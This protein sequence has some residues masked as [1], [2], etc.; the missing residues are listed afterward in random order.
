MGRAF[1]AIGA[2]VVLGGGAAIGYAVT[3]KATSGMSPVQS[4]AMAGAVAQLDGDIK[5]ARTAVEVRAST[6]STLPQVRAALVTDVGT[7]AD[8]VVARRAAVHARERRDPRVRPHPQ[9]RQQVVEP[10]ML[11]PPGSMRKSH[12][13]AIGSYVEL[14]GDQIVITEVAKVVTRPPSATRRSSRASSA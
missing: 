5:A 9:G 12:D 11:Q 2:I 7:V 8:Q 14:V 1:A 10:L 6:L 13:G 3:R 4:S